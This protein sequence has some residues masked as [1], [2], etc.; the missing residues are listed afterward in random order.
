MLLSERSLESE[1]RSRTRAL[2]LSGLFRVIA[3]R[4]KAQRDSGEDRWA[5]SIETKRGQARIGSR[6]PVEPGIDP[7][8]L[9]VCGMAWGKYRKKGRS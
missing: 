6:Q 4:G 5:F 8:Y 2:P 7:L 1:R 9:F 3:L